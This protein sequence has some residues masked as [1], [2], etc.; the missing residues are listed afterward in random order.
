MGPGQG[1]GILSADHDGSEH[2]SQLRIGS[3]SSVAPS[4]RSPS[5]CPWEDAYSGCRT[6]MD[7]SLRSPRP[8]GLTRPLSK[9]EAR[10]LS[11]GRNCRNVERAGGGRRNRPQMVP[12]GPVLRRTPNKEV[13]IVELIDFTRSPHPIAP[14][15]SKQV[16]KS[17]VTSGSLCPCFVIVRHGC[18]SRTPSK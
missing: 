6:R 16:R 10:R 14:N 4:T 3:R 1:R 8:C 5:T 18:G 2:R 7:L 9:A 12:K 13:R 17:S 15:Q 11:F